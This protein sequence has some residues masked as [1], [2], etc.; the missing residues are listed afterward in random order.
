MVPEDLV[1]GAADPSAL[2]S[3]GDSTAQAAAEVAPESTEASAGVAAKPR[4]ADLSEE[5]TPP[6]AETTAGLPPPDLIDFEE[7]APSVTAQVEEGAAFGAPGE[8]SGVEEAPIADDLDLLTLDPFQVKT[9]EAEP[10]TAEQILQELQ[11][12]PPEPTEDAAE[13][14]LTSEQVESSAIDTNPIPDNPESSTLEANP[15]SSNA[16]SPLVESKEEQPD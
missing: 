8:V 16:E 3:P 1:E 2:E 7:P 9:E 4:W 11:Q 6:E 5:A 14:A 10:A 15:D 12:S 13:S